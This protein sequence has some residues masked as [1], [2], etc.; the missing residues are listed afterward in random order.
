MTKNKLFLKSYETKIIVLIFVFFIIGFFM[1]WRLSDTSLTSTQLRFEQIQLDLKSFSQATSFEENFNAFSCDS[2][3]INYM[4][5]SLYDTASELENL[6]DKKLIDD[7]YYELLKNK[8]NVN[9]VLFYT[10]FNKYYNECQN[11]N[12]II[13]FFFNSSE[14]ETSNE[15]GI[16]LDQIV[17]KYN[18]SVIP[19]D[20]G[21]NNNLKYFYDF[22]N[23]SE[24]P[25][26]V[27]NY[28]TT[29]S[30]LVSFNQIEFE[31]N[32]KVFK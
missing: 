3:L 17:E 31:L 1:G 11:S 16:I 15:Q 29:L 26:L 18:V 2:N 14:I 32:N 12:S 23:I 6:E 4:S 5:N 13:L 21:Y 22:Y 20:Y 9:Q 25:F 27:I 10:Y 8:H 24:L 30:G 7:F 28:N 19:M